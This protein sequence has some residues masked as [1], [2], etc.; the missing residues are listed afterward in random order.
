MSCET[1]LERESH[2]GIDMPAGLLAPGADD[3]RHASGI[4]Q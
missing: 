3:E 1:L 2:G 4:D